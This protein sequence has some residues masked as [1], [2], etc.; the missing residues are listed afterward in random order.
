MI[1]LGA[2]R[3]VLGQSFRI[4]RRTSHDVSPRHRLGERVRHE[5]DGPIGP[6]AT[7]GTIPVGLGGLSP[8]R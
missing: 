8:V 4:P 5:G 6:Q 2:M 7:L 1:A 3:L